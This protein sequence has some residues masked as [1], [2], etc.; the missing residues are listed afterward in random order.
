MKQAYAHGTHTHMLTS[1]RLKRTHAGITWAPLVNESR[2]DFLQ[3]GTATGILVTGIAPLSALHGQIEPADVLTHV[4]AKPVSNEG[5]CP[6]HLAGQKVTIHPHQ[7]PQLPP[8]PPQ[9]VFVSWDALVTMKAKG[10]VTTLSV[11]RKGEKVE[12]KVSLKPIPP[13]APR[14]DRY[15]AQARCLVLSIPLMQV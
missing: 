13:L 1:D 9:Q 15:S 4:D 14:F 3:M 8:T 6:F 12:V 2:R 7:P 5:N 11:L 10:E